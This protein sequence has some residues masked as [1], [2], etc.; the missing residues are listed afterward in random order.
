MATLYRTDQLAATKAEP[1][2]VAA[3][4]ERALSGGGIRPSTILSIC[5]LV[6]FLLVELAWIGLLF[7]LARAFITG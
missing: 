2:T 3:P 6:I 7:F 4:P 5:A 1:A